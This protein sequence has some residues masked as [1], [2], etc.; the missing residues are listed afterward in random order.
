L[1]S[2]VLKTQNSGYKVINMKKENKFFMFTHTHTHTQ[3]THT[4]THFYGQVIETLA[5]FKNSLSA[6]KIYSLRYML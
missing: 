1:N 2:L 3:H 5:M 4:H 6:S